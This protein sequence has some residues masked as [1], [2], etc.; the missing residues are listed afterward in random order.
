MDHPEFDAIAKWYDFDYERRVREDLPFYFRSA[1]EGGN[2]VLELGAGTGRVTAVLALGGFDVTAVDLSAKMLERAKLRFERLKNPRGKVR[3]VLADMAALK[4]RGKYRTILVPF[5]SF[6]HLYSV[7]RQIATLRAIRRL[8]A[9]DGIAVFDL[10][11]PDLTY[12]GAIEGKTNISYERKR[13]DKG[14][15]VVQRFRLLC[16]F[17]RQMGYIEYFW[18]EYRGR[19]KVDSDR[20]LMR[21]RWFHVFEFEH[22][23]FRAGLRVIR[24]AGGF[25]GRPYGSDAREMIF[26]AGR[27]STPTSKKSKRGAR[28]RSSSA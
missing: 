25:D 6:H 26:V 16:D 5:R 23:L 13:R 14:T 15:K 4:L 2:P 20:A 8:L 10:L 9:S 28:S 21:W 27:D 11:Q 12:F 19:K 1:C 18:D 3:F 22:L 17:P 7:E 24:I